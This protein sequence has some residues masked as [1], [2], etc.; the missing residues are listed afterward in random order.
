MD[1]HFSDDEE[2]KSIEHLL[3]LY[4][5]KPLPL[6]VTPLKRSSSE[7]EECTHASVGSSSDLKTNLPPHA[8]NV[9][10]PSSSSTSATG[11]DQHETTALSALCLDFDPKLAKPRLAR[12]SSNPSLA[13]STPHTST[14]GQ[15]SLLADYRNYTFGDEEG[16]GEEGGVVLL[17]AKVTPW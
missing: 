15:G 5:P 13:P 14:A 17:S 11:L 9:S 6:P 3:R 1:T 4:K 16:E 7:S 10:G 2:M 12:S 8:A